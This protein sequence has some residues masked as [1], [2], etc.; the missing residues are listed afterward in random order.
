M[1]VM[2]SLELDDEQ[3]LDAVMPIPMPTK[4]DYPYGARICLTHKDLEH[5]DCDPSCA[6]VDGIIHGHFIG[7][8]T[9]VS[10]S[11][12]PDGPD[13]RVEIQ[14]TDLCLESEDQENAEAEASE[15]KP[16]RKSLYG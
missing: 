9:S 14:M 6:V 11:E 3:K 10:S 1:I 16:K 12:G 5:I 15:D 7:R 4:P 2:K 13:G 8:I